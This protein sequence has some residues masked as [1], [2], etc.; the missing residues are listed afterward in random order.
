MKAK[1]NI[2]KAWKTC[3]TRRLHV[4]L[5]YF[6]CGMDRMTRLGLVSSDQR[7]RHE[8]KEWELLS[9]LKAFKAMRPCQKR[10]LVCDTAIRPLTSS[11][12]QRGG[13]GGG[14]DFPG[15]TSG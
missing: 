5:M 14:A 3:V 10:C 6:Y 7:E 9:N 12:T 1:Q 2:P 11:G 13:S 8:R 4:L 15:F